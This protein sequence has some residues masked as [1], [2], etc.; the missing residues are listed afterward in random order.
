MNGV[1]LISWVSAKS[2]SSWSEPDR[3]CATPRAAR[4]RR[5]QA[6]AVAADQPHHQR[7]AVAEQRAI[8][9][10]RTGEHVV[11]HHRRDRGEQAERGG[12]QRLGDAG[13][14][15]REIGG[16][17]VGDADEAV[18]DAP[19]GAEQAD[20]RRGRADAGDAAPCRGRCA[21]ARRP[22]RAR[23]ARR[24]AP[25]APPDRRASSSALRGRRF[26]PARATASL[27][28]PRRACASASERASLSTVSAARASARRRHNSRLLASHTVQVTSEAKIR[29]T[30]TTFT[31]MSALRNMPQGDR[32]RGSAAIPSTAGT[33]LCAMACE[34]PAVSA[35]RS[36][37]APRTQPP[38]RAASARARGFPIRPTTV[39]LMPAYQRRRR[40]DVNSRARDSSP[41]RNGT[42]ARSELPPGRI[43]A[44]RRSEPGL[45]LPD[46]SATGRALR[47]R[48]RAQPGPAPE[49]AVG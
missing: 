16:V 15:H 47:R 34:S 20:E 22:R 26:G 17:R 42:A 43:L 14:D 11:D 45:H 4:H 6:L 24:R 10:D 30:I 9:A 3:H 35:K 32:S 37:P 49:P 48:A 39:R 12:E 27:L 41:L 40:A 8:A 36:A 13:R 21:A 5:G 29:P 31:T 28:S 25:S 2:S 38:A 46:R 23:A 7:R 33:W 19:D 18:H 44:D 1:T